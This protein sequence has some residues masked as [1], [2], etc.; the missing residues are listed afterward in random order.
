[1]TQLSNKNLKDS[2][3]K[4]L[5]D[6]ILFRGLPEQQRTSLAGRARIR[7]FAKGETIFRMGDGGDCLMA[8]LAG[9][10]RISVA[11]PEGRE[12]VLAILGPGEIVGEIA[13]L[14]G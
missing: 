3:R 8:V 2:A 14:D 12:M 13:V 1:M 7:A 10:V 5:A 4:L 9:R 6:C 11:S